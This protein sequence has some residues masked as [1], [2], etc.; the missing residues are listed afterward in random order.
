MSSAAIKDVTRALQGLLLTQLTAVSSSAQVSLLPPGSPLPGGLGVNLYLFKV[1][2]SPFLK[3]QRWPGDRTTPASASPALALELSYL[4]TPYAP[5]PDA[6]SASGDDA[7]TMLGA[8]ML[9][10]YENPVLNNVHLPGFD[11]D[12]VLSAALV[13]SYEQIRV[14]LAPTSMEELSKIWATINQPYRLSVAYHVS[15]VELTPTPPPPVNAGIV[16]ATGLNVVAWNAPRI[17]ALTPAIGALA[18]IS[19][20]GAL[21]PNLLTSSGAGFVLP[22]QTP[23]VQVASQNVT[24]NGTPTATSLTANLPVD[25]D[26]GPDLSVTVSLNGKKGTSTRFTVTPWLSRVSPIRSTLETNA[27]TL[28]GIGFTTTPQSVRF[29]GPGGT[30]TVTAFTGAP[31]DTQ[32]V[33]AIPITLANGIYRVRVVLAAPANS[34]SNSVALEVIPFV[35]SPI[36]LSTTKVRGSD[37]HVLTINGARLAGS[38]VRLVVDGVAYATGPNLNAAQLAFTFGRLL[39]SGTH[40]VAVVVNGSVSHTISLV[41]P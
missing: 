23:V 25:A 15:L 29:E 5:P 8:S 41:I 35:A 3:N 38:D 19:G 28:T 30:V 2:E 22:G 24:I 4:L 10:L 32:A 26:G 27:L 31:T 1:T 34:A 9:V 6:T 36:G 12:A 16:L 37:V 14:T 39:S 11:S 17:D 7:H 33:V 20:T 18:T 40:G 13:N 21:T